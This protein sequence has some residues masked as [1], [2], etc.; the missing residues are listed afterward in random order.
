[1]FR[2]WCAT[3]VLTLFAACP[4]LAQTSP[5]PQP[6]ADAKPEAPR[7]FTITAKPWFGDFDKMVERRVIRMAIPYSRSLYYNDKGQ[8]RGLSIEAVRDF[9][10]YINKKHQK[11]LG[12]R[13]ITV[14]VF[15]T[16]R[17]KLLS[18]LTEGHADVALGNLTV[19]EDR[20]KLVDMIPSKIRVNE[21]VVTGPK[22]PE[23]ATLDDLAGKTVHVRPSSSY[24]ASLVALNERFARE[25][26]KKV[27]L[28]LVP[29]ALEDED[30]M[31]M[32]NNGMFQAIVVDDWKAKAWSA[33]L[34][35]LKIHSNIE[36]RDAAVIGVAV[37]KDS[38]QLTAAI[39]DYGVV[40]QKQGGHAVRLQ[41]FSR[42]LKT[43]KDN[44]NNEDLKRFQG[45]SA[46]FEKYS[47][48]YGFEPL[49][50]AAQGYQ[51]SRLDHNAK[52]AVGAIGIMQI[53]PATGKELKVGDIRQL[54]PNIHGAAK[55]M[56]ILMEKYFADAK[57]S[58]QD[59]ALFAFASYNCGPGN[60]SRARRDAAKLGLDPNKWFNHV[61]IT[62]AK[63][64]GMETTTYVRNIF[65]Y[66][67][68][69]KMI[70]DAQKAVAAARSTVAPT[71]Q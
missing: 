11:K 67:V 8:E 57:F 17:D 21:I 71:Q 16:T 51:E 9:E 40:F 38:P 33:V 56:D 44:T 27:E 50:L 46:L 13:P 69:Y 55:Y 54:E 3:A 41:Q 29:D 10:R 26:K 6:A 5:T 22:S 42:R 28:V 12:K 30:M 53:M 61:E 7:Q 20:L 14:V 39:T 49:M 34:K 48:Q 31:E 43:F 24:H 23:I 58:D 1:M 52:S 66:Y 37:R 35:N 25:G 36:L 63:R 65:K 70:Q 4:A 62:I 45:T 15:P 59:R 19:T 64:I 32:L 18:A 68:A 60:V 2:S 47:T